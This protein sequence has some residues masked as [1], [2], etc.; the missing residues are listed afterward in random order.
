MANDMNNSLMGMND[1]DLDTSLSNSDKFLKSMNMMSRKQYEMRLAYAKQFHVKEYED[2]LKM[3]KLSADDEAQIRKQLNTALEQAEKKSA[4]AI[5]IYRS[6]VMKQGTLTEKLE[7]LKSDAEV[8]KSR[9]KDIDEQYAIDYATAKGNAA[10]R[11]SLT[12]KHKRESLELINEE[13]A[14]RKQTLAL[15]DSDRFKSIQRAK[16]DIA[17]IKSGSKTAVVDLI[18]HVKDIDFAALSK[19]ADEKVK[20]AKAEV[21]NL[22]TDYE[23]MVKQGA[24]E[25]QL[26]EKRKQINEARAT[27]QAAKNQKALIDSIKNLQDS[28]KK[29]FSEAESILTEYK[30]TIDSRLQGSDKNYNDIMGKVSTNLSLSPFVKTQNVMNQMKEAVD[31]GIAY[32]VEQ[33]A[34]LASI[35]DKIASTFDA[36]DNNLL[37]LIRL[38]QADTTA[39][40]LGMEAS[41]TKFFNGMFNDTSY[42]SNLADAVSGAILDANS[43]LDR[44]SSAEFEYIVQKWLGSLASVGMSDETI[45]NIATGINYLATGDVTSLA[46]NTQLQT[47]F[48]MSA[49]RAGLEYSDLLL[50]GLNASNTNQLLESMVGY[51]KDIAENSDNQVVRAAYGDIFNMSLSD[52]KAITNLTS[53]DISTITSDQKSYSAFNSELNSQMLQLITRTSLSEM[54][55]NLYNNAVFGVA[56]DM[57]SNPATFAMTKMLDMMESSG[58]DMAIPFVNAMGFGVDLNTSVQDILRLGVG[59]SSAFSLMSNILGGLGS[60]GGLNLDVWG[61]TEYNKRGGMVFSTGSVFGG[62]TG[63]TYVSNSSSSDMKNSALSSATDDAENSKEITN[64]NVKNTGYTVDDLYRA[65]VGDKATSYVAVALPEK[66]YMRVKEYDESGMAVKLQS[67]ADGVQLAP[68]VVKLSSDSE[69]KFNEDTL[70]KAFKK[71]MGFGE[72]DTTLNIGDLIDGLNDGSIVVRIANETGRRLQVDTEALG[73]SGYASPINW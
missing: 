47:L 36:F 64:K 15:E 6:N 33:R 69:V 30:G 31:K 45:T 3:E 60:V 72:K 39:A 5:A 53:S 68:N 11:R 48:A 41:L 66:T 54:M 25:Q 34:F 1:D 22:E 7:V 9:K 71:A 61:A 55:S 16:R 12:A 43:Q 42:L 28:Y 37:R 29:A 46:S 51:L 14:L 20:K 35:T 58:V 50:N 49:S 8:L 44:N 63:S 67:I 24:S 38:Q 13:A 73:T 40:R 4:E 17:N 52:M 57:V 65:V 27:E 70:V 23:Q 21:E 2:R 62:T 32:N 59:L 19:E 56:E 10:K 26:A 18:S